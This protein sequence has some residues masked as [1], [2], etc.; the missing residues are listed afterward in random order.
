MKRVGVRSRLLTAAGLLAAVV[1]WIYFAPTQIGGSTQYVVTGGIS[2]A[3][4]FHTGD[5]AIVRPATQY[6]VGD[7]VAYHSALL[8]V[9][10]LHRIIARAGARY[11]FKGDNNHFIDPTEPDRSQLAGKLWLRIP[12]GGAA[13]RWLHT[14]LHGGLIAAAF[15]LLM[16][17]GAGGSRQRRRRRRRTIPSDAH[18]P[19]GM[20]KSEN[21]ARL[22][23]LS[24][25]VIPAAIGAFVCLALALFAFSRPLQR[26]SF[27]RVPY[28]QQV[29]FGYRAHAAA[30][31]VYPIG[32][33]NTGDP[34]FLA[35]VHRLR[36]MVHYRLSTTAPRDLQGTEQVF[37]TLTGSSGW[38]RQ[39][40]LGPL[41]HFRGPASGTGV[42]VD[43]PSVESLI[44]RVQQ[45]TG[46]AGA[47]YTVGISPQIHIQGELAGQPFDTSYAPTLNFTMSSSQ[48]QPAGA[49]SQV[50][51]AQP[52]ASLA[53]TQSGSLALPGRAANNVR[54]LGHAL[55]IAALR[56]AALIGLLLA[57]IVAVIAA[58][59]TRLAP[60]DEAARIQNEYGHLIVPVVLGPDGLGAVPVDVATIAALA[61]LAESGQRLIL[62]SRDHSHDTY[63]VKDEDAVYR[64]R[65]QTG[66]VTWGEWS[67]TE[68]RP[69]AH[70]AAGSARR[71]AAPP[72]PVPVAAAPA[73]SVAPVAPVSPSAAR[74]PVY[75]PPAFLSEPRVRP[76]IEVTAAAPPPQQPQPDPEPEPVLQPAA[77]R[78]ARPRLR[79]WVQSQT[80]RT[81]SMR[82]LGS[83]ILGTNRT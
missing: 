47:S 23:D 32:Q 30:G 4:R 2:M 74:P 8:H 20:T 67:A 19:P 77:A 36:V 6:R 82:E 38:S 39:L 46:G 72:V 44:A 53:P 14:P 29:K 10:V 68:P 83:A 81:Q 73:S 79:R 70:V 17:L 50:A 13:L 43:L 45:Q 33:V 75:P 56:L 3:P 62:H 61:R 28:V 25:A 57:A 71:A 60:S 52:G 5:L 11:I 24:A 80:Q 69:L 18:G 34:I 35:L 78:I 64:Y 37:L 76:P 9:V 59:H 41:E 16:L 58:V 49:A 26:P 27:T 31:A 12:G 55:S 1:V 22:V 21:R 7:I 40:Q 54:V 63:L 48:L 51:A 66:N 42:T 15:G 65:A